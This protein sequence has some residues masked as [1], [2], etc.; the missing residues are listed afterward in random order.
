MTLCDRFVDDY[1]L[2]RISVV[3]ELEGASGKQRNL[4]RLKIIARD[5]AEH[6]VPV[7]IHVEGTPFRN[8]P[9]ANRI[10]TGVERKTDAAAHRLHARHCFQP[11]FQLAEKLNEL[12]VFVLRAGQRQVRQEN[13]M[14]VEAGPDLLETEEAFDE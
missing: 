13:V 6:G 10:I 8:K 1:Y 9:A 3:P 11:L 14:R 2:R 7:F 5:G 12:L 4:Q